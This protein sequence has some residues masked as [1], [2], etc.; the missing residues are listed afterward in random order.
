MSRALPPLAAVRVFEAAARLA[1]FT[2]AGAELGMTQA[3]VSYQI[4]VL[5]ERVGAPLFVRETRRVRLTPIGQRLALDCTSALDL[6]ATGFA[7]ARGTAADVL[8]LTVIPTFA[9][10]WLARHLGEFQMA[11]PDLAVRSSISRDMVDLERSEFDVAIRAG[12]GDWPGLTSH[13]L[14]EADF[15]PMVSPDYLARFGPLS[16]PHDIVTLPR[17]D[18]DDPWWQL[19]FERAGVDYALPEI[20]RGSRMGGQDLEAI[21]AMAGHGAA[22]LTPFFYRDEME[23]GQLLQ[24]HDIVCPAGRAYHVVYPT[25]RRN[26][27]KI[28]AFRDWIVGH[29]PQAAS[30]QPPSHGGAR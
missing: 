7:S 14:I 21:A 18:I 13:P 22:L 20:P 4:K 17:I 19:W 10:R 3:A 8:T 6:I 12:T 2:Q 23:R 26:V 16:S 24:P 27:P 5:E 11:H 28:R 15:T 1:S 25:A 29:F 9:T 30:P